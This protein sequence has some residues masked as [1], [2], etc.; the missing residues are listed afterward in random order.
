MNALTWID[1]SWVEGNPP[2]LGP[3]TQ[4]TWLGSLVFDGARRI[5]GKYPDLDLHCKRLIKSSESMGLKSPKSAEEVLSI[6]LE[7]CKKFKI[8]EDL[9]IKPMIWAEDGIGIIA[10]DPDSTRLAVCIFPAPLPEGGMTACLSSFIRP[11][12]KAAPTDAKAAALYANTGRA[13][14][15]AKAKG[16]DNCVICD[17]EGNVA[18]FTVA[19]L[20]MVKDNI[21]YTPQPTGTFLAG[22]TR[23]RVMNLLSS[24]K[25]KVV[26]AKIKPNELLEADEIFCT[27]NYV[28]LRKIDK[29]EDK[30][31]GKSPVFDIAYHLYWEWMK[32]I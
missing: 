29:Y 12:E 16:F 27:G 5:N 26:E 23:F 32:T 11:M 3:M 4:S 25:I 8:K 1:G 9:Y 15:E 17:H 31:F 14:R 7:G 24:S 10:P 21:V 19:N 2:I 28:K 13:T 30:V 6:C 18:E 22:I 20:F